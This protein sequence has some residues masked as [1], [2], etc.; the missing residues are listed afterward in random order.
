[1]TSPALQMTIRMAAGRYAT[2]QNQDNRDRLWAAL[3]AWEAAHRANVHVVIFMTFVLMMI[4]F[5]AVNRIA[6][7][8]LMSVVLLSIVFDKCFLA[9]AEFY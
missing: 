3:R 9:I 5:S 6:V 1:M 7:I 8:V 4:T 2:R